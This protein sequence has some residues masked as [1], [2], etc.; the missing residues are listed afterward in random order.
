[1]KNKLVKTLMI[2]FVLVFSMFFIDLDNAKADIP[3]CSVNDKFSKAASCS[4]PN[5]GLFTTQLDLEVYFGKTTSGNYCAEIKNV[6]LESWVDFNESDIATNRQKVAFDLTDETMSSVLNKNECPNLKF[7]NDYDFWTTETTKFTV[8][9]KDMNS[10]ACTASQIASAGSECWVLPGEQF[11]TITSSEMED[12]VKDSTGQR[13]I[14]NGI[15]TTG[16]VGNTAGCTMFKDDGEFLK[17]LKMAFTIMQIAGVVLL[18][19]LSIVDFMRGIASDEQ[20]RIKKLSK[21]FIFR[22]IA[23]AIL[24]LAPVIISFILDV[25]KAAGVEGIKDSCMDIF[26]S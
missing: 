13:N 3:Y 17:M 26:F 7:V 18:I 24:I 9:D 19:V 10:A 25:L 1:M 14:A 11:K 20:D 2:S 12:A 22:L 15:D 8:S 23:A 5:K 21:K 4:Y 16:G 6:K